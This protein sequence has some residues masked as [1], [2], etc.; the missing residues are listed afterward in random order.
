MVCAVFAIILSGGVVF[1]SHRL[2]EK[3]RQLEVCRES[4]REETCLL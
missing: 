2:R 4:M 3:K 1:L